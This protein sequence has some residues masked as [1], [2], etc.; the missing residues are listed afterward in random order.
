M[1]YSEQMLTKLQEDHDWTNAKKLFAL[2]LR[3]DDDDTLYDLGQ[4]LYGLG[5][6]PQAKRIFEKLLRDHPEEDELR[7]YLADIA[8]SAGDNDAAID[9]LAAIQPDSPAYVQGLLATADVYQTMG[10]PEVSEQKLKEAKRLA[11]DEPVIDFALA[12]LYFTLGRYEEALPYYQRLQDQGVDTMAEVVIG[13]R[14]GATLAGM[15]D[16]EEAI[17]AYEDLPREAL[18]AD[19]TYQLGMLYLETKQYQQAIKTL[20]E[21]Q[22]STPDYAPL[23]PALARAQA[24][25]NQLTD[26]LATVHIGLGFDEFN[27]DLLKLGFNY[28]TRVGDEDRAVDF[29]KK[30]LDQDPDDQDMIISLSNLYVKDGQD[31]ANIALLTQAA[32]A[33]ELDPQMYWNIAKSYEREEKMDQAKE[34]Y[35]LAYPHFRENTDFLLDLIRFFQSIAARQELLAALKQYLRLVPTDMAMQDLYDDLLDEP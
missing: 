14:L 17:T 15:G 28:A 10:I 2:A 13:Q 29:A 23:Y 11:P 3:H 16:Y 31:D 12:E 1:S 26:A 18:D 22:Q 25:L 9:L 4:Q 5:F 30:E 24:G 6:T 19:T 34:N 27:S 35:L 7:T 32:A 20:T 8:V 33:H 21:L